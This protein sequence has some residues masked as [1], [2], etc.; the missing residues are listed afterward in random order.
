MDFAGTKRYR[1]RVD[2]V[3]VRRG[4][5]LVFSAV[6]PTFGADLTDVFLFAGVNI[7]IVPRGF[8]PK[9]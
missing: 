2:L 3:G 6:I 5:S 8:T 4:R 7:Y 1:G 9:P